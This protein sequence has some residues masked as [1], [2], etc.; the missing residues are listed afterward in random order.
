MGLEKSERI[1]LL[2]I[3]AEAGC[4]AEELPRIAEEL[5]AYVVGGRESKPASEQMAF[6][7][8]PS[9]SRKGSH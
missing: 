1:H 5:E 7:L 3:A 6:D 9:Q 8:N 2:Q 4:P